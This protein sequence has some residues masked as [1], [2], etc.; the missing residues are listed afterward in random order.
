M[1]TIGRIAVHASD[2]YRKRSV[3]LAMALVMALMAA[4]VVEAPASAVDPSNANADAAG[5]STQDASATRV[6]PGIRVSRIK[7]SKSKRLLTAKVTWNKALI[8]RKGKQD[9]FRYRLTTIRGSKAGELKRW[10]RTKVGKDTKIH[11]KLSKQ[12]WRTVRKA[13]RVVLSVS[14][15]YRQPS[16]KSKKYSASFVTTRYLNPKSVRA[17]QQVVKAGARDCS[18]VL[19]QPGADLHDCDLTASHLQGVDVSNSNLEG[20]NAAYALLNSATLAGASVDGADFSYANF[21]GANVTNVDFTKAT[22]TGTNFNGATGYMPPTAPDLGAPPPTPPTATDQLY[23][24][25]GDVHQVSGNWVGSS[26]IY[27]SNT[28]GSNATQIIAIPGPAQPTDVHVAGDYVYWMA[29][30]NPDDI[31]EAVIGRAPL[32]SPGSA[33]LNFA[34]IPSQNDESEIIDF[35]VTNDSILWT[36]SGAD[37]IGSISLSNPSEVDSTVITSAQGVDAPTGIVTYGSYLYWVNSAI[38]GSGSYSIARSNL[39]GSSPDI[40]FITGGFLSQ[41]YEL[42]AANQYL[43][44]SAEDQQTIGRV[45]V[46]GSNPNTSF[47]SA[48]IEGVMSIAAGTDSI[49]WVDSAEGILFSAPGASPNS[50]MNYV[51]GIDVNYGQV[52][53]VAFVHSSPPPTITSLT[54]TS[55]Q[56]TG[57]DNITINGSGF[58]SGTTVTLGGDTCAIGGLSPTSLT[59]TTSPSTTGVGLVDVVVT[60]PDGQIAAVSKGF[61]YQ[62]PAPTLE[63]FSP[64]Q[65]NTRGGT[66]IE[67]TGTN[68][69]S[70]ATVTIAGTA[71][72]SLVVNS[73]TSATCVTGAATG[74]GTG[75]VVLTNSDLQTAT[76][77]GTFTYFGLGLTSASPTTGSVSGG[78]TVE[79]TGTYFDNDLAVTINDVPCVVASVDSTSPETSTATCVAG[80]SGQSGSFPI[81]LENVS[82]GQTYQSSVQ[83]TYTYDAAGATRVFWALQSSL[84]VTP[85]TFQQYGQANVGVPNSA[86]QAFITPGNP[87]GATAFTGNVVAGNYYYYS[88]PN[89]SIARTQLSGADSVLL[90]TSN[91]DENFIT[92]ANATWLAVYGGYLYWTDGL[93][94]GRAPVDL[95]DQT[96]VESPFVTVPG[97]SLADNSIFGIAADDEYVYWNLSN[98][99]GRASLLDP[100]TPDNTFLT[101]SDLGGSDQANVDGISLSDGNIYYLLADDVDQLMYI[102]SDGTGGFQQLPGFPVDAAVEFMTI[103]DGYAYWAKASD[104]DNVPMAHNQLMRAP[105][106]GGAS[107]EL[108]TYYNGPNTNHATIGQI[109][110]APPVAPPPS[111]ASLSPSSGSTFGGTTLQLQGSNFIAGA[112]VLV[113]DQICPVAAI[114]TTTITCTTQAAGVST[115]DITVYNPDTQS[116]TLSNAYEYVIIPDLYWVDSTAGTIG[117]ADVDGHG[118]VENL[119]GTSGITSVAAAGPYLYWTTASAV[120]RA[121]A[122]GTGS[123]TL[124]GGQSNPS[125]ITV[126]DRYAFWVNPDSSTISRL[127]LADSVLD[128]AF[129]SDPGITSSTHLVISGNYLYWTNNDDQIGRTLTADSSTTAA[130]FISPGVDIT[131]IATDGSGLYYANS[132][133]TIVR[134][135]LAGDNPQNLVVDLESVTGLAIDSD[136]LYWTDDSGFLGRAD[137]D[138]QNASGDWLAVA[139]PVTLALNNS[140]AAAPTISS[141]SPI[142]PTSGP[143]TGGTSVQINGTGFDSGAIASI[144]GSD[145]LVTSRSA[146]QLTCTTSAIAAPAAYGVTVY[147]RST[148]SATIDNSFVYQPV[149]TSVAPS[150]GPI[151]GGTSLTLTGQGF[152]S[153]VTV[154]VGG[155]TC[156]GPV[157]SP[158]GTTVAC[159]TGSHAAGLSDVV[160]TNSNATTVTATG[161]FTYLSPAPTVTSVS[162]IVGPITGAGT[163][164]T[165]EGTGF[166][167][168][169]TVMIGSAACGS[170]VFDEDQ[171]D[172]LT[173]TLGAASA[174]GT[175]DVTVTSP[176]A[177]PGVAKTNAFTYEPVIDSVSP[178]TGVVTG[179]EPI[180][181]QGVG[182]GND[183]TVSIGGVTCEVQSRSDSQITC[184][185]GSTPDAGTAN[186]TVT[187]PSSSTSVTVESAFTY[188][189]VLTGIT[190]AEGPVSGATE[191][192]INGAGFASNAQFQIGGT[193]CTDVNITGGGT[194]ATCET[195]EH[196]APGAAA[197]SVLNPNG[198]TALD[199]AAFTYNPV[200]DVVEEA[201]GPA[202]GNQT[203]TI[204]GA[205]FSPGTATVKL[206]EIVCG[207]VEVTSNAQL[208]CVSGATVTAGEVDVS[209]TVND[210]TAVKTDGYNYLPVI[211]SVT[212]NQG[213]A[214]GGTS[215]AVN[216]F[217]LASLPSITVGGDTCAITGTDTQN[218]EW[219]NCTTAAHLAGAV[220]VVVSSA[221]GPDVTANNAFGYLPVVST[222]SPTSGPLTGGT[223]ITITGAGFVNDNLV[224]R[225]GSS[226]CTN[227]QVVSPTELTCTDSPRSAAG[228]V[229]VLVTIDGVTGSKSGAYTYNPVVT[230]VSPQ[231]GSAGG[232]TPITITGGG[233]AAGA[234]VSVGGQPCASVSV[235]NNGSLTCVTSA[236]MTGVTDIVVTVNGAQ[237]ELDDAFTFQPVITSLSQVVGPVTGGTQLTLNGFGLNANATVTIGGATCAY[238]SSNGT[239]LTCTTSAH[240]AGVVSVQLTNVDTTTTTASN[241]FTYQPVVSSIAPANGPV[242]GHTDVTIEGDGFVA[243]QTT[244][245][246]GGVTCGVGEVLSATELTCTTGET[247]AAGAANVAV[248]VNQ[249]VGTLT[250]GFTYQPVVSSVSPVYGPVTGGTNITI[251]GAGFVEGAT[252]YFGSAQCVDVRIESATS[253]SCQT[254][255]NP[256]G[257]VD[258]DVTINGAQG[259]IANAFTYNPVIDSL[260]PTVGPVSGGTEVTINGAGFE[261]DAVITV[262]GASCAYNSVAG[263]GTWLKCTTAAHAAGS[264]DVAVT[265]PNTT[266]VTASGAF[267]YRPVITVVDPTGAPLTGGTTIT[268]TGAGFISGQTQVLIGSVPCINVDV[269]GDTSLTCSDGAASSAGV[270]D[271]TVTVNSASVVLAD[272]FTY[273][274]V[275]TSVLPLQGSAAGGTTVTITGL[276]F[277]NTDLTVDFGGAACAVDSSETTPTTIECT[278][279]AHAAGLVDLT[280]SVNGAQGV[281]DDAYTYQPQITSLS[282]TSGPV[283]GGTEVTIS[284]AGFATGATVSFGGSACAVSSI[285]GNG[286]S[287]VCTTSAHAHGAVDVVVTNTNGTTTTSTAAFTYQPIIT[288]ITPDSVL[289]AGLQQVGIEGNG[290]SSGVSV[291]IGGNTCAIDT[292]TTTVIVCTVAAHAAGVVDVVV[293]NSDHTTVSASGGFTYLPSV[294]GVSPAQ[295]SVGGGTVVTVTG[296]GF[297]AGMTV[298]LGGVACAVNSESLTATTVTCTTGA[299]AHG[300]VNAVVTVNGVQATAANAYTYQPV[301]TEISPAS[302]PASGGTLTVTG[303]GF[304]NGIAVSVAAQS[305]TDVE[306]NVDGTSLTCEAPAHDPAVVSV[307]VTNTDTTSA[308]V[309]NVLTYLP[310]VS[311]VDPTSGGAN[312]TTPITITGQGFV[313]DDT[314]V[315]VGGIECTAPTVDNDG[316]TVECVAGAHAVAVVDIEVTV[317]S[318]SST[319]S[320]GYTYK[321]VFTSVSPDHG[322]VVGGGEIT[323]TGAGFAT[324][325]TVSI[326]SEACPIKVGTLTATQLTCTTGPGAAGPADIVL[327]VNSISTTATDAFTYDPVV[328]AIS[329]ASGPVTG[330]TPVEIT[331]AGFLA[332]ANVSIGGQS[333]ASVSVAPAGTSL[334]CQTAAHP[335]G[336]VDVVVTNTNGS[337]GTGSA[338]YTYQPVIDSVTPAAVNVESPEPLALDITGAGFD[339]GPLIVAIGGQNCTVTE[340]TATTLSCD[341]VDQPAGVYDVSVTVASITTTSTDAF[342]FNPI[343]SDLQLASDPDDP[344][345]GPVLGG[346]DVS[347]KG[348]GF[349]QGQTTVTLGSV[350]CT[351]VVVSLDGEDITC[352]TGPSQINGAVAASVTVNGAHATL[353]DAFTYQGPAVTDVSPDGDLHYE[354]VELTITGS[355]FDNVATVWLRPAA[356][357]ESAA[358]ECTSPTISSTQIRCSSPDP[359]PETAATYILELRNSSGTVLQRTGGVIT[360]ADP[361]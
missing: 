327:T 90:E 359:I 220:D 169:S 307:S 52:A 247:T 144:G 118:L 348:L 271:V 68:F 351:P 330:A 281:L 8:K 228:Q 126:A 57:G 29:Y 349:V 224:V 194:I 55:G 290:F 26:G 134:T 248:S 184:T 171:P 335:V 322:S 163:I 269:S 129:I 254:P 36:D 321:P 99:I 256:S 174:V 85:P 250:N 76:A 179:G 42:A 306:V 91:T 264:A 102:A 238:D 162:P 175:V 17:T 60:N 65:S 239:S 13:N 195:G 270:V 137:A 225:F 107:P 317:N 331:G 261:A 199:S 212:P 205:G 165:I 41:P 31:D 63:S 215:I 67:L 233:F 209:I 20:A 120:S 193:E 24:S 333:C 112:Q 201:S 221:D 123:T 267:T 237:G 73:S 329:P 22:T 190:P 113:G 341:I 98:S 234:Q 146:T 298:A 28:D 159:T 82:S 355:Q 64:E 251:E 300:V 56:Y 100:S 61:D 186:V 289:T 34:S 313:A 88:T 315:E 183:A 47:L 318:I 222:V 3:W 105:L 192:T 151:G 9:N 153:G 170:V 172:Q 95:T 358:Y 75:D 273:Q 198:T 302:L 196:L 339:D 178:T 344:A 343:V 293:T 71:C 4:F 78:Q 141:V 1:F 292:V 167:S 86:A 87:T 262:G 312:G 131:A 135:D 133:G 180:E 116:S 272:A 5:A 357:V 253:L 260:T 14:Q 255:A 39:D 301:I 191:V 227:V 148:L 296:T 2:G 15:H 79:L 149:I 211:S 80:A 72:A 347:I 235:V 229:D 328:D 147:N 109:A 23:F 51:Y 25:G 108:V 83:F 12:Q 295:G 218:G 166:K 168:G 356:D 150:Q 121:N 66:S 38:G 202:N 138:G 291:T 11:V 213:P 97:T 310:V 294:T 16:S 257:S 323:I 244:V 104:P 336:L 200:I 276:G 182:F 361:G 89:G 164:V 127:T 337:T 46:D 311:S 210:A 203:I 58:V 124:V 33:D 6:K 232:G 54:P 353:A 119:T 286:N 285:A 316:T 157:R 176:F 30:P 278:T 277:A 94:I 74:P 173:C 117:R 299:H 305:C 197:V 177:Y 27:Q 208:S 252:V 10:S 45:G 37:V 219:A 326:G 332:D 319:L 223:P 59:C 92:G 320:N 96:Q 241:A 18:A 140:Q 265:N 187:N 230:S 288:L 189:P 81:V 217:G 334:T 324:G 130:D 345:V 155:T 340:H 48:D 145:C 139:S 204:T 49:F 93:N 259:G 342:T 106:T 50:Q 115:V 240:A 152:L 352:T 32:S 279:A 325:M 284:G 53:G 158:A 161:S 188:E 110:L 114:D 266:T 142:T 263:D 354:V 77:P 309:S 280:V 7:L 143:M 350:P 231:T 19:L 44:W 160:L 283:T 346:T 125:S 132:D 35:T 70:G 206:G 40:D 360:Y 249:A 246:V 128:A 258:V 304:S 303:N 21:G 338:L 156:A 69:F 314:T 207:N 154:T 84:D 245:V 268:I 216:G 43:Y 282:V 181:I 243:G 103:S 122:D 214:T 242:T 226:T 308:A 62:A 274:P 236:H 297:A 275:V 101:V 136:Y 111:L 287:V 185:S